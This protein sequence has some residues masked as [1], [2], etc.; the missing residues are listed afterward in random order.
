[1]LRCFLSSP[2]RLW[3]RMRRA[4]A[5]FEEAYYVKRCLQYFEFDSHGVCLKSRKNLAEHSFARIVER[6]LVSVFE[7]VAWGRRDCFVAQR[8][9][10]DSDHGRAV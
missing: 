6:L 5:N 2:P 3:V 10:T 8:L 4:E 7:S 1:M 9:G